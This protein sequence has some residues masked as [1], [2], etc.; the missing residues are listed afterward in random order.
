[1]NFTDFMMNYLKI[2]MTVILQILVK[3]ND[4]KIW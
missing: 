4:V 3:K 2:C 1:M